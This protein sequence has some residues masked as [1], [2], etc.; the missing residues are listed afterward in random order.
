[1][2]EEKTFKGF[3][4]SKRP[5]DRSQSFYRIDGKKNISSAILTRSWRK[6]FNSGV[7]LPA[8]MRFCNECSK[9]KCC[10]RCNIQINENKVIEANLNLLRRQAPNQFGHMLF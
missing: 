10:D 7:V 8:K 2:E 5:Q 1:M 9:E 6:S 4:D 3:K